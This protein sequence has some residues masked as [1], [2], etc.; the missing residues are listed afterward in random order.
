MHGAGDALP[1][2]PG[3]VWMVHGDIQLSHRKR[4]PLRVLP[5]DSEAHRTAVVGR[6][7]ARCRSEFGRTA[8]SSNCSPG[9][10]GDD[11]A[12]C[13]G[14]KTG[15]GFFQTAGLE[16]R[17]FGRR[18]FHG[19]L[20]G[21]MEELER[22]STDPAKVRGCRSI[23]PLACGFVLPSPCRRARFGGGHSSK[24][25]LGRT[26]RGAAV[27]QTRVWKSLGRAW[28]EVWKNRHPVGKGFGRSLGRG[29]EGVRKGRDGAGKADAETEGHPTTPPTSIAT[30]G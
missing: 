14:W 15:A 8:G 25:R 28:E 6:A 21:R 19:V 5:K 30:W 1:G 16:E 2:L 9:L 12:S 23:V 22:R 3:S 11:S 4:P 27:G 20:A 29:W 17:P 13:R 26:P 7:C 10:E 24:R 18:F